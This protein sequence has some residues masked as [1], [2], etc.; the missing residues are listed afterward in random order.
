MALINIWKY[1]NSAPGR[2]DLLHAALGLIDVKNEMTFVLCVT[3]YKSRPTK[4]RAKII[5]DTFLYDLFSPS[6]PN[7]YAIQTAMVSQIKYNIFEN[8]YLKDVH[9]LLW[10]KKSMGYWQKLLYY[11]KK[12]PSDLFD[13]ILLDVVNHATFKVLLDEDN[14]DPNAAREKLRDWKAGTGGGGFERE[15][16]MFR[17]MQN[18]ANGLSQKLNV[19]DG[20][21]SLANELVN[22]FSDKN[23]EEREE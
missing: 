15:T 14:F 7:P 5:H 16:G 8:R 1:T 13:S 11:K 20:F 6:V 23:L 10:E 22:A 21:N 4:T 18:W 17:N 12:A 3:D 19:K 9:L 2:L